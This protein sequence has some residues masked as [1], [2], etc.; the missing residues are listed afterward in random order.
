VTQQPPPPPGQG[1]P[2]PSR[3]T[4]RPSGGRAGSGTPRPGAAKPGSPKH[5]AQEPPAAAEP[6]A[7]QPKVAQPKAQQQPPKAQP[8][9]AQP[10]APGRGE[11]PTEFIP[12]LD[13]S[14]P[15]QAQP[16]QPPQ[17]KQPGSDE[18]Q[19]IPRVEDFGA[20]SQG[21]SPAGGPAY[22]TKDPDD[23]QSRHGSIADLGV[24]TQ[25]IPPP[26]AK[27]PVGPPTQ[28]NPPRTPPPGI[29]MKQLPGPGPDFSESRTSVFSAVGAGGPGAYEADERTEEHHFGNAFDSGFHSGV[30]AQP[31]VAKKETSR[32]AMR[33]IGEVFI[34]C[35]MVVLLFVVYE[36]YVTNIFSAQKQASA[37]TTL[38]QEWDTVVGAGANSPARQ[39]H[40]DLSDGS[41]IAKIYIPSLGEDYHYTVI[42]GTTQPDLA[43]GPGHYVGSALPG[44]PGDFA[45]AGHRVGEG[46]PF[47]EMDL[48]Q[49]CDAIVIETQADWFV[50]RMLPKAGEAAGWAT[51]K[52][53]T[54]QCS[55]PNGEGKVTPLG[56]VYAQ[57]VGQEIVLPSEGDVV[58]TVPHHNGVKIAPAQEAALLTLTTCNPKFS[59]AQR[60]ILHAVLV[61]DWKKDAGDPN[62]L[63]PELKETS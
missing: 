41:G 26:P 17:A 14:P 63:P 20:V 55:G 53:K 35:G 51:G 21:T 57:T 38:D 19:Y 36:L 3:A 1:G 5:S 47:N 37:T 42:E 48:V 49:S 39:N 56:G 15:K 33:A 43:I 32:T 30:G 40:Y 6:L 60:M 11:R 44:E 7:A 29:P 2:W 54:A 4:G 25:H 23:Y 24:P 62:K 61:K 45:I 31:P 59:A 9:G 34:T 10:P 46:A 52:G 18:T 13:E 27:P 28:F 16:A 58:A 50:Y 8:P 12:K 22:P